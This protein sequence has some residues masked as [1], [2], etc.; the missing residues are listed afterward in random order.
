MNHTTRLCG[1]YSTQLYTTFYTAYTTDL[2]CSAKEGETLF[3]SGKSMTFKGPLF[4]ISNPREK[5]KCE[6]LSVLLETFH[7]DKQYIRVK[8]TMY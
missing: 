4:S 5:N 3:L 7:F 6:P 2:Q 1:S 8:P